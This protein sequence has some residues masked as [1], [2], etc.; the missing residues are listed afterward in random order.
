MTRPDNKFNHKP[1]QYNLIRKLG[2]LASEGQAFEFQIQ[3]MC[4]VS[5]DKNCTQHTH[6]YII[7]HLCKKT[8]KLYFEN[9]NKHVL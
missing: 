9:C 6:I 2:W 5:D 1:K 3:I 8:E 4:T 7:M